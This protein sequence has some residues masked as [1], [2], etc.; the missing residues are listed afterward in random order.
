MKVDHYVILA[1]LDNGECRALLPPKELT[2]E[3][4]KAIIQSMFHNDDNVINLSSNV[5][6]VKYIGEKYWEAGK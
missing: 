1:F 2:E 4:F 6:D 5:L 3:G